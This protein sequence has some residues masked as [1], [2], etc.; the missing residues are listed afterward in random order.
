MILIFKPVTLVALTQQIRD[1]LGIVNSAILA[2]H[3]GHG[4][5]MSLCMYRCCY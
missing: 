5:R 2:K 4:Q 3:V 1:M